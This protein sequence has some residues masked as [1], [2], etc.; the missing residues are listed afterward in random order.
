MSAAAFT[1]LLLALA[2]VFT[3]AVRAATQAS[4]AL[5]ASAGTMI[6]LATVGAC[7][8][9]ALFI[10]LPQ[11]GFIAMLLAIALL[12]GWWVHV[13]RLAAEPIRVVRRASDGLD[14]V[15]AF[16]VLCFTWL[17]TSRSYR[18][19]GWDAWA[20]WS[21]HARFLVGDPDWHALLRT[22]FAHPD[23]PLMQPA[24]IAACWR[25]IDA[26]EPLSPLLLSAVVAVLLLATVYAAVREQVSRPFA[27]AAFVLLSMDAG[28]AGQTASQYADSLLG[29]CILLATVFLCRSDRSSAGELALA[30]FFSACA[31]WTKNEGL[32]FFAI[33]SVIAAWS[34]RARLW[35][36]KH[37]L[38]G[39]MPL[40]VLVA[41]FKLGFAPPSDLA[42]GIEHVASSVASGRRHWLILSTGFDV[43]L[44]ELPTFLPLLTL[45]LMAGRR[46]RMLRGL[47]AV[48]L[49]L[50]VY[51]VTYLLTPYDLNWHLTHSFNR[52]LHHLL[53]TLVFITFASVFT[54]ER[55]QG[56]KAGMH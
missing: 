29:L 33:L 43:A 49:V 56:W 32:A 34:L 54:Q 53:P 14:V 5:A 52:L 55:L 23:Y 1:L 45:M 36:F 31:A 39:S 20:Q 48:L 16:G 15:A 2:T 9:I 18:W 38:L 8:P 7:L 37:F 41:W 46:G 51:Y 24:I 4:M 50:L 47:M 10:G 42:S 35:A 17:F 6:M 28:F 44:R 30:G 40:V 25:A 11:A 13:C 12:M 21:M 3:F 19:G 26:V 27:V 22:T